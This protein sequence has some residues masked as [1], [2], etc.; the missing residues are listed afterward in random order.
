MNILFLNSGGFDSVVL[1][2]YLKEENPNAEI[3][4]LFFNY[5]QLACA[6]ERVCAEKVCSK[7]NYKF[8]EIK[9]PTFLWT[10]SEFYKN[11][12]YKN[13]ESVELEYRNMIFFSYALSIAKSLNC[14]KVYSAI[15]KSQGYRYLKGIFVSY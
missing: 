15:L 14:S 9:L 12:Q 3:L 2:H 5:N 11:Q 6:K 1:A 4:G 13:N 8:K 7:L 10:N